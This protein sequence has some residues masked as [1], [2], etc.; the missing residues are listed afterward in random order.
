MRRP[1]VSGA[2]K[3]RGG[4]L[5]F[6]SH[7]RDEAAKYSRLFGG[8]HVQFEGIYTTLH[9]ILIVCAEPNPG[10]D[11][12]KPALH[13]GYLKTGMTVMDLTEIPRRSPL[14]REAALRGC[15]IVE[16]AGLLLEQVRARCSA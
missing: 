15:T 4:K 8:R 5:I 12:D 16:P 13:P 10:Q 6:G 11:H 2:I 9:D 7:N 1:G 3:E 14:L